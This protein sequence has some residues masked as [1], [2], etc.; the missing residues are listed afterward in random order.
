MISESGIYS[1]TFFWE[2][3]LRSLSSK[4]GF[5]GLALSSIGDYK[6]AEEAHLKSIQLDRNFLEAWGHL[7]Q[8]LIINYGSI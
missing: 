7:I 5:Q 1:R 2:K 4:F 6:G 3:S 8:V